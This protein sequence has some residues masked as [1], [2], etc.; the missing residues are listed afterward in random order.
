MRLYEFN[1]RTE[2]IAR[3]F[4]VWVCEKLNIANPPKV[5]LDKNKKK[6]TKHR[7]F[8]STEMKDGSIWVYIDNRNTAD[9]LRTLA[10]EIVHY[11]QF[12]DGDLNDLDD[13]KRQHIEDEA[14]AIAGRLMREYG[15]INVDIYESVSGSLQDASAKSLPGVYVVPGLKNQDPYMQYRFGVALAGA[16]GAKRRQEDNVA[17]FSKETPWGENQIIVGYGD[18]VEEYIDDALKQIGVKGKKKVSSSES[19]ESSETSKTSPIKP[20]KGYK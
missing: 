19:E 5:I 13:E 7:A 3:Q 6:V 20:F 18:G 10:H 14:N 4:V 2:K 16:K 11:K 8:G 1:D 15:K 17:S 9:T 12:L